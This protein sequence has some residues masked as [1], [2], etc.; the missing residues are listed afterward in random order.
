[1]EYSAKSKTHK[2]HGVTDSSLFLPSALKKG[3]RTKLKG[4][5]LLSLRYMYILMVVINMNYNSNI[6]I[7]DHIYIKYWE[8]QCAKLF[9]KYEQLL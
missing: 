6:F 2:L 5:P 3:T 4:M 7:E 8:L 1:M 9:G